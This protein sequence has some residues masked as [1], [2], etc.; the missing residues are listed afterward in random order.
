MK[1][2]CPAAPSSGPPRPLRGAKMA[3]RPAAAPLRRLVALPPCPRDPG[4]PRAGSAPRAS[5]DG[6][7]GGSCC[8]GGRRGAEGEGE[9]RVHAR[10]RARGKRALVQCSGGATGPGGP[11]RTCSRPGGQ[12]RGRMRGPGGG[13]WGEWA[14]SRACRRPRPLRGRW[15][16]RPREH[17]RGARGAV[18]RA[19]AQRA[20]Q[21]LVAGVPAAWGTKGERRVQPGGGGGAGARRPRPLPL[22]CCRPQRCGVCR[23]GGG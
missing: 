16:P 15:A 22:L 18:R 3:K 20:L 21:G 9:R 2:L 23:E 11:S 12:H 17:A 14:P 6:G 8:G 10:A 19:G 1:A 4:R 7:G 13:R 5:G